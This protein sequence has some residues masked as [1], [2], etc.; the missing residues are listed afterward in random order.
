MCL[1]SETAKSGVVADRG[2]AGERRGQ[3]R[4]G[5]IQR[6]VVDQQLGHQRLQIRLQVEYHARVGVRRGHHNEHDR[7]LAK[8]EQ[9]MMVV[10]GHNRL[11]TRRLAQLFGALDRR[12][13]HVY[14]LLD[15]IRFVLGQLAHAEYRIRLLVRVV[16]EYRRAAVHACQQTG[17]I[18]FKHFFYFFLNQN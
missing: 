17:Q 1:F 8:Y 11:G 12:V 9:L 4:I 3:A 13:E 6:V 10:E 5:L 14:V 18:F 2:G 7:T 15:G 16:D